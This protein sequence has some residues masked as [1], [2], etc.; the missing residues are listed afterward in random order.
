MARPI[1]LID[2]IAENLISDLERFDVRTACQF[3]GI[4]NTTYY[5]WKRAGR[6]DVRHGIE[7]VYANFWRRSERARG[8]YKGP[9]V[10]ALRTKALEGDAPAAKMCLIASDRATWGDQIKL[11]DEI[12]R[13]L[14]KLK[15]GLTDEEYQK[16][17]DV[18][19]D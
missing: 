16:V 10:S 7:S 17:L 3:S 4:A 8:L 14:T 5:N 6:R 9:I 12:D 11:S 15:Q 13:F 2:E 19:E 18:V 1:K